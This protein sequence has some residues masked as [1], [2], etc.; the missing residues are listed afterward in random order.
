MYGYLYNNDEQYI[1]LWET[2]VQQDIEYTPYIQP[3]ILITESTLMSYRGYNIPKSLM[4]GV[5]E[6]FVAEVIIPVEV[7]DYPDYTPY[8]LWQ[9]HFD[10]VDTEVT[11]PIPITPL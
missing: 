5:A 1:K 10:E 7:L 2:S 3:I 6:E 11:W 8:Q 9:I 4:L